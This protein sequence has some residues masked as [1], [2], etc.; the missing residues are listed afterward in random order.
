MYV[1]CWVELVRRSL[2]WL[3]DIR[4]TDNELGYREV[5]HLATTLQSNHTLSTLRL[6]GAVPAWCS[7]VA[8]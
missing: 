1:L 3:V 8:V 7:V 5:Q 4:L 6:R 2:D